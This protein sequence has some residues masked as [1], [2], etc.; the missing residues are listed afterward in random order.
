MKLLWFYSLPS[1]GI[2]HST[3][4]LTLC[5]MTLVS[6]VL[7]AVLMLGA[8]LDRALIESVDAP[9]LPEVHHLR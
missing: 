8:G 5:G 3:T 7:L 1:F 9:E 4:I 6:T 2:R